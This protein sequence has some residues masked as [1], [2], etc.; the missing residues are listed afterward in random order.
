M[1]CTWKKATDVKKGQIKNHV[2][3][4]DVP[5]HL[6]GKDAIHLMT[7]KTTRL[8]SDTT[9]SRPCIAKKTHSM[10]SKGIFIIS[11][12]EDEAEF[13]QFLLDSGDPNFVV[14]DFVDIVRNVACHF[15]MHPNGKDV[16]WFGS[17]VNIRNE[18]ESFSTASY[19]RL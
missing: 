6:A 9:T 2:N 1:R 10:G 8:L 3:D 13:E 4:P 18:D 16:T 19:L 11:N 17:T 5:Y 14:T 15:F 7:E 12:D